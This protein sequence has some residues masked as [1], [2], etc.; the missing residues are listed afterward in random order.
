MKTTAKSFLRLVL[1]AGGTI[2]KSCLFPRAAADLSPSRSGRRRTTIA[3]L[4][5]S[6]I[7]QRMAPFGS[8]LSLSF[9]LLFPTHN[10][11]NN[12]QLNMMASEPFF[13]QSVLLDAHR[14]SS[15]FYC[16]TIPTDWTAF[17]IRTWPRLF[18][19]V[20]LRL[21]FFGG[22][23]VWAKCH[24]NLAMA[25]L[26]WLVFCWRRPFVLSM[27]TLSCAIPLKKSILRTFSRPWGVCPNP[28]PPPRTPYS[29]APGS[30]TSSFGTTAK[31]N[32]C[33]CICK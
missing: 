3:F 1:V 7:A 31:G 33:L 15:E 10:G 5:K 4:A 2:A 17:G 28:P 20:G 8:L 16:S 25:R 32:T 6:R 26:A 22:D 27:K 29:F 30:M 12:V 18:L 19:H 9:L 24:S 13:Y 14:W 11:F 21:V 23:G